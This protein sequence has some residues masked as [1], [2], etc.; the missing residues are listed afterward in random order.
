MQKYIL[1]PQHD[2]LVLKEYL[3]NNQYKITFDIIIKD[4]NKFYNIIKCEKCNNP[5]KLSEF[6]LWFGKDNFENSYSAIKDY[7]EN[8]LIKLYLI[9]QNQKTI[10]AKVEKS[11]ML[12]EKAKKELNYE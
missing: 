1:A 5:D 4:K 10:D 8:N 7:V 12:F 9:K 3:I 11:I 6:E 2:N